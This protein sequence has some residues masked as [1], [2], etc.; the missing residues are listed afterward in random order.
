LG[1]IENNPEIQGEFDWYNSED[2]K[3]HKSKF[4]IKYIGDRYYYVPKKFK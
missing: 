1:T 4:D 2:G 3:E